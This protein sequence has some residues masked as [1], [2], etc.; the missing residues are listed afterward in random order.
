[1]K[2]LLWSPNFLKSC[3]IQICDCEIFDYLYFLQWTHKPGNTH[4]IRALRKDVTDLMQKLHGED[5]QAIPWDSRLNWVDNVCDRVSSTTFESLTRFWS[6]PFFFFSNKH[7]F[8]L[9]FLT[10][11]NSYIWG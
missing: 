4:D 10:A 3:Y 8:W 7:H 6:F 9:V 5:A 1:M 2:H 11:R